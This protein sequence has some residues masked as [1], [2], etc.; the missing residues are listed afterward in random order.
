MHAAPQDADLIERRP[1][2][3]EAVTAD[4]AV[5]R[6]DPDHAT[7]GR[8]L[9]HPTAGLRTERR[10]YRSRPDER[11]R[12]AGGAARHAGCIDWS[13]AATGSRKPR[14]GAHRAFAG[15]R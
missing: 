9:A 5:G 8:R 11:R 3:N 12:A 13:H 2:R 14:R 1:E 6:L 7:K 4:A 15:T 10:R